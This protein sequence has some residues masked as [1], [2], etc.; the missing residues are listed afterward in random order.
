MYCCVDDLLLSSTSS[1]MT[2]PI[3]LENH[4]NR[5]Q[6]LQHQHHGPMVK[7]LHLSEVITTAAAANTHH[8]NGMGLHRHSMVDPVEMTKLLSN[9]TTNTNTTTNHS[10]PKIIPTSSHMDQ[11]SR[12]NHFAWEEL[13][14]RFLPVIFRY[15]KNIEN[16]FCTC[17]NCLNIK[18]ILIIFFTN[19]FKK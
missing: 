16:N 18:F 5:Q 17:L 13:E 8:Y 19:S 6:H 7:N 11:P 9:I 14:G 3:K 10:L 4:Q 2:S 1:T 12:L 15:L